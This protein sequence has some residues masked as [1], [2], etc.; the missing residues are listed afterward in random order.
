MQIFNFK[1]L[2]KY[3][4]QS[5]IPVFI[6][7]SVLIF[8]YYN[9]HDLYS[10]INYDIVK[11]IAIC[12]KD[13]LNQN[14]IICDIIGCNYIINNNSTVVVNEKFNYIN[15]A[16]YQ[17]YK[18]Y[19]HRGMILDLKDE[20]IIVNVDLDN[21]KPVVLKTF[22]SINLM[23]FLINFVFFAR[24]EIQNRRKQVLYLVSTESSIHEKN[25]RLLTENIHHELN[26]PI[27]IISGLTKRLKR[28]LNDLNKTDG[29]CSLTDYNEL[30]YG[31]KNEF[32]QI[33][34]CI[35][36]VNSVLLRMSNFKH[37]RYS[38][39][40]K[41]IFDIASYSANSMS[42]LKKY[43]FKIYIDQD[44]KNYSLRGTLE[45]GDL[46]GILSN[47]FKNSIEA[48][49]TVINL[50]YNY[51]DGKLKLFITDNGVGIRDYQTGLLLTKDKLDIVFQPYYSTKDVDG[52]SAVQNI[53]F[54]GYSKKLIHDIIDFFKI[55]ED[56]KKKYRGFGLYYIKE[57]LNDHRGD[58]RLRET[59]EKGTVFELTVQA[60]RKE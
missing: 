22:I 50:S 49:S 17:D 18:N 30:I 59:S 32:E 4:I 40:N 16:T 11:K 45:N 37:L 25:M 47:H 41:S 1:C 24:N 13:M 3:V 23:V 35:E 60:K 27:A 19:E 43:N 34:A 33:D 12:S 26:T 52:N 58:V 31:D 10:K 42:V 9:V 29:T 28:K 55:E 51:N 21:I 2:K 36:Q 20:K 8:S 56:L 53:G 57:L 54:I 46:L 48:M 44:L 38:N 6:L 5:I 7:N 39:G 15:N 14:V